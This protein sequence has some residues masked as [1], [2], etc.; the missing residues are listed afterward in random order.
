MKKIF[1]NF[2]KTRNSV[3]LET[4]SKLIKFT[5]GQ[6][7]NSHKTINEEYKKEIFSFNNF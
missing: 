3:A 7:I 5:Y 2:F 1:S 4:E 6:I